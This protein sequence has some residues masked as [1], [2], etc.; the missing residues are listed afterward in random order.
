MMASVLLATSVLKASSVL[1]TDLVNSVLRLPMAFFDTTPVGRLLNRF[2]K[3]IDT[4]DNTLPYNLRGWITTLLQV[5]A[6]VI[7][8]GIGTPIFIAVAVPIGIFYWWLQNVYVATSRQ[9]KRLE[10]ISRSPIYSHFGETLT[11]A[12]VIRAYGEQQRFILESENRVDVNQI[13][14]Y[15]SIIANRWLSVRLETVG[16][17]VVLFA[18]LFAVIS[19]ESLDPGLVGLSISYALNITQTLNWFMR[20]TSE[21]ETNI[22]SVER[23]IDYS[24]TP[25]EA[26]WE[27]GKVTPPKEWPTNGHI[28]FDDYQV[29]YREGLDLVLKGISCEVKGGEKV[30]IV[31]R[32]G[33][34]KSSLTLGLFRI[35]EAASGKIVIDGINIADLA[36]HSLRSRITIIPQDPVLFSGSLRMNLDPFKTYSDDEV[37]NALEHAHLKTFVKSLPT[38]LD[39]EVSEGGENLSIGQRQLIC[40][41]RALLRKTKVLVLDEAT[42]A[43]DL[44]TDDLIQATIRKEFKDASVVTIAHRLN[45]I[46]DSNRVLVLDHGEIKEYAP[47]SELLANKQSIFYGMAKDAGLV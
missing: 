34:G 40:L 22:V 12:S 42:A 39:H 27:V 14:Y 37:W 25:Q 28:V 36:L 9:L 45:T 23:I 35:I 13:C 11:G 19:R 2:S 46:M 26:S 7:I 44:E 16:N 1:H 32:T 10:S 6:T 38:N 8:I 17:L 47:P 21:V 3:D 5:I 18:A 33:A 29:R 41:A 30:G 15:P 20:M 24:K 4:L 43:V 31:G